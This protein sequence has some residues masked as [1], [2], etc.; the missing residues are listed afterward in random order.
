MECM[1]QAPPPL[2]LRAVM[3]HSQESPAAP[4]RAAPPLRCRRL[5]RS[6]VGGCRD[7][8]AR[9]REVV[10][11]PLM[12]PDKYIRLGIDPPKGVRAGQ[13]SR[14][15]RCRGYCWAA[16]LQSMRGSR[17]RG[18]AAEWWNGEL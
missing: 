18:T 7:Q 8:I 5:G 2:N 9:L 16:R 17:K 13:L 14:C 12:S 15:S 1:K 4:R 6:D 3:A 10:E 11:L